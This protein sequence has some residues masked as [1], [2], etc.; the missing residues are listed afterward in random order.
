MKVDHMQGI[1]KKRNRCSF[2]QT[3]R[4]VDVVCFMTHARSN[5]F[6]F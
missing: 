2:W 4:C 6:S 5:L 3:P 1:Q